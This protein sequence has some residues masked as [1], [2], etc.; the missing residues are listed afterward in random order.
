MKID[1]EDKHLDRYD[2]LVNLITEEVEI[3][4]KKYLLKEE[5]DKFFVKSN[6]AAGTRIRLIMQ[7]IK[8]L[9]QEVRNDVQNFKKEI[10]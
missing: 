8:R 6:K 2:E 1:M 5:F 10:D 7:M 3:E 4:G 9:S